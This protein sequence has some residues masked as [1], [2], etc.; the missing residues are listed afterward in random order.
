MFLDRILYPITALGPGERIGIWTAGCSRR[1]P[2]CANPELWDRHPQQ[3][4]D[5]EKLAAYINTLFDR[6]VDGITI[7]GGEPFEQAK[8]LSEL[9]DCLKVKTEVLVFSGN[10]FENLEKNNE[11]KK[12]LNRIDVLIDG[13][14]VEELNDGV[15][16]LRGSANQR[17]HYL[18]KTV[19][20]KYEAYLKEGRKIQNFIY[21]YRTVS[22]GIHNPSKVNLEREGGARCLSEVS[23]K[24]N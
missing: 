16:A 8:E 12:F 5:V 17:I 21:D 3:R 22:V 11:Y 2:G 15:A 24:R 14:Y 7:T 19:R 4:I 9:L 6:R 23:G 18:N 10:T 1:C 13:P 20:E